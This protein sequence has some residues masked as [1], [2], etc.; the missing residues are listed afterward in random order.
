VLL[1]LLVVGV[2]LLGLLG[3]NTVLGQDAF[4]RHDL[5]RQA[6]LLSE[7]EQQLA[8]D[9]AA[10]EAPERLA[11]RAVELGLVPAGPPAFLRLSDGVV[12]GAAAAPPVAPAPA[13]KVKPSAK[14]VASAKPAASAK[15]S[16]KPAASAKPKS[17]AEPAAKPAATA[18]P[19]PASATASARPTP[20]P[21]AS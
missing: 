9:V 1:S 10:L 15:P 16:A 18:R 19:T 20:S 14:P 8:S 17:S 2:G 4:R 21:K 7:Q 11:A 12:L 5:D 3:L 13:A 6:A